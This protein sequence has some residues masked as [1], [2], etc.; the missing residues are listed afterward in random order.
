MTEAAHIA[1]KPQVPPIAAHPRER[2]RTAVERKRA[3]GTGTRLLAWLGI[4][5]GGPP[6]TA[7]ADDADASSTAARRGDATD[8][9]STHTVQPAADGDVAVGAD[10]RP[11]AL[12]PDA[13]VPIGLLARVRKSLHLSSAEDA[14]VPEENRDDEV[15]RLTALA[16]SWDTTPIL[17]EDDLKYEGMQ[18][19]DDRDKAM[20]EWVKRN[21]QDRLCVRVRRSPAGTLAWVITNDPHSAEVEAACTLLDLKGWDVHVRPA[22]RRVVERAVVRDQALTPTEVEEKFRD[23]LGEA[24]DADASDVHFEVRGDRGGTRF[25]VNGEMQEVTRDDNQPR[26]TPTV[27][28]QFGNYMF[29]RLAKRGS[30][31]FVTNMALNASAQMKVGD[32][33]VALRFSTAPDIRGVDIFVRVWR[34]DQKALALHELGYEDAHVTLLSR[35]IRKPYGVILFSGPTGS[36]KSSSL[37]ALL[38]SLDDDEKKRRK[39]VSLEEP[40]ERE[41][42]HVTHVSV[43]A[44]TDHGGWTALLGGLNRWDS[45]VNVLGEIKDADSAKALQDLA[46]SGKLTLTTLHASNVISI[47]ARMEELG[48]DHRL[49]YDA[50]FLVL[51][52]NQRL[53][54]RL[55]EH[56]RIPLWGGDEALAAKERAELRAEDARGTPAEVVERRQAER[57]ASLARYRGFYPPGEAPEVSVRGLG[58]P[59][60]AAVKFRGQS[61]ARGTGIISRVLVAEMISIDEHSR[62]F[63]R[64]R[65]WDGWRVALRAGGWRSIEDH[66]DSYIRTGTVDPADVEKLV[67][68]LDTATTPEVHVG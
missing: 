68:P 13:P 31:Q 61:G 5:S 41:L 39:I 56:C 4:A 29:N 63:I 55:C 50:N 24:L 20:L 64:E 33:E 51:L 9:A 19:L 30:R 28:E 45:N 46:T 67:C 2:G 10:S 6:A 60:C 52:V 1:S 48:V 38:D 40:V 42:P 17:D 44:I 18:P 66:V 23:L 32:R 14:S 3:N 47:P 65:D 36:G 35:A 16:N 58:C 59:Q 43:S 21:A 12:Q 62:H 15:R 37:T 27:I 7:S 34:P 11:P 49:L 54:P 22:T 8:L 26:F 53:V 25:R 57:R